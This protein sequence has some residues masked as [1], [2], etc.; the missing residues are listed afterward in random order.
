MT[1]LVIHTKS[2]EEVRAE[3]NLKNQGFKTYLPMYKKEVVRG[4]SIKNTMSPLFP[5]YLFLEYNRSQP[6]PDIGLIRSTFG[7]H[8]LLK[9]HEKPLEIKNEIISALR[10]REN[11]KKSNVESYYQKGDKIIIKAGPF[12]GIEAIF[13]CED[14]EKRA[15]LL[16]DLINKPTLISLDKLVIKKI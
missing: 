7:V 14:K 12:K 9:I 6:S 10:V 4:R 11:L 16:F 3:K 15:V 5:R 1:W 13:Q 2:S 8:Q